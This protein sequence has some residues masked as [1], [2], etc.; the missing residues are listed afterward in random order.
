MPEQLDDLGDR[1]STAKS[2]PSRRPHP[3]APNTPPG[4]LA[5]GPVAGV[6]DRAEDAVTRNQ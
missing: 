6:A 2:R 4:N 1:L 3:G 5:A